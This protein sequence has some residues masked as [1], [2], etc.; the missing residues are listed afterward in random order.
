MDRVE[1]DLRDEFA[2]RVSV[3]PTLPHLADSALRRGKQARRRRTSLAVAACA[4]VA[5]LVVGVTSVLPS[6]PD[7]APV[8]AALP[9]EGPPRVP[10]LVGP[11]A[12]E[13]LDWPGGVRRSRPVGDGVTPVSR[14]PAGLLVVLGGAAP[15]LG[16]LGPDDDEP[17]AVVQAL[18]GSDVAVSDDGR[19]ATVVVTDP[20]GPRLSEVELPS[21]R[22]LRTVGLAWPMSGGGEVRPVAYSADAVLVSVGAGRQTRTLLWESGDDAVVGELD[23]V[24]DA[25]GGA[26]AEFSDEPDA[27]G[28]RGA[29]SVA[30]DRCPTRVLQLRN[31]DGSPWSLCG[32]DFAG[33]SP[34]GAAVLGV[35]GSDRLV[36]H[37]A[38]DGDVTRSFEVPTGLLAPGWESDDTLLYATVAGDRT[39][40][41]RCSVSRGACATA[42]ELPFTDRT[43]QP[44]HTTG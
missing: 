33:F 43:P 13:V 25:L 42:T 3:A 5:G 41:V 17:R 6:P 15:A 31:G 23:G 10:L 38:D 27:V 20:G 12:A 18:A 1:A 8:V 16:L 32:E 30:D 40:V 2:R 39:L 35:S 34:D 36:V 37:D 7:R 24:L 11:E 14:V 4:A 44:V 21:G 9:L 22:L 19:R 29:F 26:A 28:G